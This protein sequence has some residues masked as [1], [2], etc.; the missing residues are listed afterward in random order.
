VIV[1]NSA[2]DLI[3]F[4]EAFSEALHQFGMEGSVGRIKA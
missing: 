4:M 3:Q 2:A 1:N